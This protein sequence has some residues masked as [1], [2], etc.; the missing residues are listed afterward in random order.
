MKEVK[1]G[2]IRVSSL[3]Q[4]T[5]RQLADLQLDKVF[6][7]K[8]SGQNANRPQLQA[9]LEYCR[10]GDLLFIHSID[11][12]A[13]NLQD[14]LRLIDFLNSK[15]V[16]VQ[17]IK[18]NLI[19]SG[20]KNDPIHMLM[21]QII[22]ACAQFERELI[23]ERQR[24]GIALARKQGKHLGRPCKLTG[25]QISELQKRVSNGESKQFLAKEYEIS[26]TTLFR[27]LK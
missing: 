10:E 8:S 24:E 11:R 15:G 18:E 14:L 21:L 6:E 1:I 3:D 25:Q 2:Y 16:T 23:R 7:D 13:R 22:G 9:C 5:E 27:L 20:H 19:F 4:H 17:F 12:L 26:R